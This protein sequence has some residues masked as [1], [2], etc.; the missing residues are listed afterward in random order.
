MKKALGDLVSTTKYF[1][2]VTLHEK[3]INCYTVTELHLSSTFQTHSRCLCTRSMCLWVGTQNRDHGFQ[4]TNEN[5]HIMI[6]IIIQMGLSFMSPESTTNIACFGNLKK[7]KS[8]PM[9]YPKLLK[10]I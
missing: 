1:L 9:T 8:P 3:R 2:I 10:E 7:R 5:D 4:M 6:I